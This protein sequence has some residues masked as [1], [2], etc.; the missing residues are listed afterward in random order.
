MSYGVTAY[1]TKWEYVE[2][3][4]YGIKSTAILKSM[5]IYT[6]W[7]IELAEVFKGTKSIT[8]K[9]AVEEIV[10]GN[11]TRTDLKS[12]A[13]YRYV[14]EKMLY[15]GDTL[16]YCK[17]G[18]PWADA[19]S[20]SKG[21]LRIGKKL[22]SSAFY[23]I[24]FG[25]VEKLFSDFEEIPLPFPPQDDFPIVSLIK[26]GKLVGLQNDFT[27]LNLPAECTEEFAGWLNEA[28]KHEQDLVL[29]YY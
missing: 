8:P 25:S 10:N 20:S 5:N 19:C 13:M 24:D 17:K 26:Y 22:G 3:Y 15:K 23:P 6:N 28:I 11:I 29:Y 27:H 1:R 18:N 4:V 12:G 16:L 9:K 7:H 14:L 21:F 2:Q